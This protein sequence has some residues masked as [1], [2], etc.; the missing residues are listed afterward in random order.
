MRYYKC[1]NTTLH[2]LNTNKENQQS[3]KQK[4]MIAWREN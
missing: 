1:P 3:R 4:H 2:Y